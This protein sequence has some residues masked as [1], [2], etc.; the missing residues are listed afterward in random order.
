M[1][2]RDTSYNS[3]CDDIN[4]M[5]GDPT[6]L[7]M[8]VIDIGDDIDYHYV[9]ECLSQYM[10][11]QFDDEDA[12]EGVGDETD[13]TAQPIDDAEPVCGS[14]APHLHPDT[15]LEPKPEPTPTPDDACDTYQHKL[16]AILAIDKEFGIGK[17]GGIPWRLKN[18]IKFFYKTTVNHVVI[19]GRATYFSIDESVRPLKNRVNIV[20][21]RN[22]DLPEYIEIM[23]K[24]PS[25]KFV[26]T[27]DFNE[28]DLISHAEFPF[29]KE[30]WDYYVMGGAFLYNLFIDHYDNI[31]LTR[32]YD[33]Y[34]CDTFVDKR[35]VM[36][37]KSLNILETGE[38]Y[39]I[40]LLSR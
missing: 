26:K 1:S 5:D 21:T 37:Y 19:M 35:I 22:P 34:K 11:E 28:L 36:S 25:V 3:F 4:I 10:S 39:Q 17:N 32:V 33:D 8:L 15:E 29:L 14:P 38:N 13:E 16:N 30:N 24:R 40:E 6:K 31:Y 9:S 7:S 2:Y 12:A 23:K 20:L 27:I 18:D